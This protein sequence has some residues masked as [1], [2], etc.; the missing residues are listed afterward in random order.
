MCERDREGAFHFPVQRGK[1]VHP[2]LI[3]TRQ[4]ST[5][6]DSVLVEHSHIEADDSILS[7]MIH[8]LSYPIN[9]P[10]TQIQTGNP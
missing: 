8:R 5:L 9:T 3:F 6:L 1:E 2:F 4:V 7:D 10:Y